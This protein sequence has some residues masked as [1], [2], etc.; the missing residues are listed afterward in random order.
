MCRM[1]E[2][3]RSWENGTG[4]LQMDIYLPGGQFS[5]TSLGWKESLS[6]AAL[7]CTD[8]VACVTPV[9]C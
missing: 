9:S 2:K 6:L 3:R 8:L 5:L 1:P 7:K 4:H